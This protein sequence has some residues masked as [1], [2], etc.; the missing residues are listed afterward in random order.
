MK[1]GELF[2]RPITRRV[3]PVVKVEDKDEQE[4][5]SEINEYVVTDEIALNF[6]NI[7]DKHYLDKDTTTQRSG[8]QGSSAPVRA[9]S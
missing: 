8:S 1:I 6:V 2:Q 7:I 9:S 4:V 3:N 5:L